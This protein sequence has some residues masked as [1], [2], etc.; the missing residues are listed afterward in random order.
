VAAYILDMETAV[1]TGVPP[2]H[3][4]QLPSGPAEFYT[5]N[6]ELD[7]AFH[8]REGLARLQ[9][10]IASE[11]ASSSEDGLLA[12][13]SELEAWRVQLPED[14]RPDWSR[15]EG[16]A[17]G[18]T[19]GT[20]VAIMHMVYYNSLCTVCWALVRLMSERMMSS[21]DVC[22]DADMTHTLSEQTK[23]H[24]QVARVASRSVI[25]TLQRFPTN[26]FADVWRVLCYPLAASIA[27]LAI[28]CKEPAHPDAKTDVLLLSRFAQFLN[29]MV[30]D[31]GCDLGRIRDGLFKF[32]KVASDAVDAA[33]SSAM[34]VHPALWPLIAASG[35]TGK[36]SPPSTCPGSRADSGT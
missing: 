2:A 5:T 30:V 36:V 16:H 17:A 31:E 6:S 7:S 10:R 8:A 33:L 12:L 24:R 28:V 13:E 22:L 34:P 4:R 27:L 9:H 1:N 32:E 14:I 35:Q 21:P 11:L 25:H 23:H 15:T 3:P 18:D 19:M 29:M 26:S 20:S